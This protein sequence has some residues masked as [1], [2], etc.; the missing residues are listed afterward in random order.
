MN[1]DEIVERKIAHSRKWCKYPNKDI[2]PLWI[3]DMDFKAAPEIVNDL[4]SILDHQIYGYNDFNKVVVQNLVK[5]VDRKL[6]WITSH[7]DYMFLPGMVAG[8]N[9]ACRALTNEGD[10]ILTA[11]PIYP[12]FMSSVKLAS[13]KLVKLPLEIVDGHYSWNFTKL[14]ELLSDTALKIKLILLCNPHNPV[15]RV[16]NK[17]ELENIA[18]LAKKYN[19]YICSDEIHYGLVLDKNKKHIPI[20]SLNDDSKMRTLTLM[21]Q[22]KTFNLA[23]LD[24]AYMIAANPEI[25][26]KLAKITTGLFFS[27]NIFGLSATNTAITKCDDWHDELIAYLNNNL[28]EI[29]KYVSQWQ[30]IEMIRQEATYLAWLDCRKFASK[31]NINN[32]HKW[33][34]ENGVGLGDGSDFDAD[35]FVRINFA[36]QRAV[37]IEALQRMKDA[38]NQVQ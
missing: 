17:D 29:I 34:E 2:I 4:Q 7:A 21:A 35:G 22:S 24:C 30:D 31:H 18:A 26:A 13:R 11:T 12:P 27:P 20:A 5:Y 36:T 28:T 32:I 19:V 6:S 16:W 23:G 8:I 33:F 10:A 1:F 9:V 14:E 38:I 37:L 3:A 15:G 25:R